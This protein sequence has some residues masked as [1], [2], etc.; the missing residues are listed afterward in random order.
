MLRNSTPLKFSPT[1]VC[2]AVDS[3]DVPPGSMQQLINLIPDPTTK[4]LFQC[5]P[6]AFELVDFTT[7]TPGPFSSG[8]SPGFQQTAFIN[9][10]FIS[11]IKVLGS[12]VYGLMAS[13]LNPGHDEPFVFN[14]ATGALVN[15]TGATAE[16]TPVSPNPTGT[17]VPPTMDLVG[18]NLLVTHPGYHGTAGIYFGWFDISQPGTPTWNGGNL[19]GAI[20][21][22]TT[23][24]TAVKN[25]NGRAYWMVN[26]PAGQPAVIF[27]DVLAP[28]NVTSGTQVLTFDDNLT[29]TAFGALNL[30]NQLGGVIQALIVFKGVSNVYQIT[31]DAATGNLAKNALNITTGTLAPNS[32]CSTPKGLAFVSPEGLRIIDFNAIISDPVGNAGLGITVPFIDTLYPSR[33]SGAC[34]GTVLRM[35][36]QNTNEL[37]SPFQEYWF[38]F[39]R[40][41]WTGPH[42]CI[43]AL[44]QPYQNSFIITLNG[45]NAKLF[46]SDVV[47]GLITTFI[48]NGTPLTFS[49]Q[50]ALL[51]D[52]DQMAEN[53]MIESTIYIQKN[54]GTGPLSCVAA[55]QEEA[56]L[57]TVTITQSG[58]PTLW[59]AFPWGTGIWGGVGIQT[60]LYPQ[61]LLWTQPIVFRRMSISVTGDCAIGF[62][63]GRMHLR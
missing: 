30:Q 26:P 53:S 4:N 13:D 15:L 52:T 59:G 6:A 5:R 27:S 7:L 48:E 50:T 42:T 31:G 57:D 54:I 38:D 58:T 29:L 36:T 25:F 44:A 55:N 18:A 45:V 33:I 12:Y 3:T 49:W 34:G 20:M 32:V 16:N 46:R 39:A 10:G 23:P 40:L 60:A 2:D 14:I 11:C 56:A 51:P 35:S 62:E 37:G 21:F 24:P 47:Q 41:C 43:N 9:A 17:W 28:R 19:T 63:I 8:F 1:S 22:T 61:Q